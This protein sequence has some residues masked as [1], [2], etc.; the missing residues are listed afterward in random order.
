MNALSRAHVGSLGR[1]ANERAVASEREHVTERAALV[2]GLIYRPAEQ[3]DQ[4]P[5]NWRAGGRAG[6]S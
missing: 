1:D 6:A 2:S 5:A 3:R 4:G